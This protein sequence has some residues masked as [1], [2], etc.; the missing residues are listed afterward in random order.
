[1]TDLR[2]GAILDDKPV[3]C[4]VELS[5]ALYRTLCEYAQVHAAQTGVAHGTPERLIAPMMERFMASDRAFARL[6]KKL[7]VT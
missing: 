5:G 6:R 4:T 3:K 2:L 1:M 7:P